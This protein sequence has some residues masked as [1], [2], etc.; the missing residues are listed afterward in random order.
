V[1]VIRRKQLSISFLHV[2][3]RKLFVTSSILHIIFLLLQ[4]SRTSLRI[5]WMAL[6]IWSKLAYELECPCYVGLFKIVVTILS[7]SNILEEILAYPRPQN[8]GHPLVLRVLLL[9]VRFSDRALSAV[10]SE[11]GFCSRGPRRPFME[12]PLSPANPT[13]LWAC[14]ERGPIVSEPRY[15]AFC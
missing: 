2:A 3:L 8:P 12:R 15:V 10:R 4:I 6:I 14:I 5:G 13:D 9:A 1:F 7:R 11:Y